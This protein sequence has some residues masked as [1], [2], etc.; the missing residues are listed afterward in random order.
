VE[1]NASSI[2][3]K[4]G[5][6]H[7]RLGGLLG[8]LRTAVAQRSEHAQDLLERFATDL[9]RHMTWEDADLFPAVRA[10]ATAAQRRSIESLEIDHERLRDTLSEIRLTL[11]AGDFENSARLVDWLETLLLG[12]N[13]DE[14]HGVYEEADRLLTPEERRSLL[15]KFGRPP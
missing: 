4:L 15:E 9:L 11:V 8:H 3:D 10:R 2:D 13:Y 14:E 6:D 12:H 5:D 1:N 7:Q